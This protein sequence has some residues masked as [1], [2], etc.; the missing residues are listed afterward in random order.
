MR[1][2]A[3]SL[4]ASA[5]LAQDKPP[6]AD[7]KPEVIYKT[8]VKV[9]NILATVHDKNG[10]IVQDLAK[11]DF[12]IDED[13]RAQVI[14]YFSKQ[15]D[16]PLTLG[17]LVD[18]SMSMARLID[19]ERRAS[20]KFFQQV[21]RE[22][23]D[24]A[25][26]IHFD[27]EVELL[28]DLT[29]SRKELDDALRDLRTP[30][31]KRRDPNDPSQGRSRG[32]G[33]TALYDAILLASDELMK[34]QTGR[35]ALILLSDGDDNGSRVSLSTAIEA[36]QRSDTLVYAI[37]MADQEPARG[38]Q[39]SFGGRRGMG[40]GRRGPVSQGPT[41]NGKKVMEQIARETGGAFFDVSKKENLDKIYERIQEELRNQY[42]LGFVPDKSGSD[43]EYRKLHLTVPKQ[44]TLVVQAR[45]GYYYS[46][47]PHP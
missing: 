1:F 40:G 15:S 24:Q 14:S 26:V 3:I 35:K 5:F 43:G 20:Y 38:F 17:L 19:D 44:K 37:R 13:G 47:K 11:D 36:A 23:K 2:L 27:H 32:G 9:V 42:S 34:K 30:E 46:A 7:P 22:D 25:F 29:S 18:T 10:K 8:D 4:C 28:R 21:L 45:D 39:P 41:H 33:G 31:L 16:Q 12:A 6:A